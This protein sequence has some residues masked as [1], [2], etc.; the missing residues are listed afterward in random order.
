MAMGSAMLPETDPEFFHSLGQAG[1][2]N[3]IE[4]PGKDKLHEPVIDGTKHSSEFKEPLGPVVYLENQGKK[5]VR[6][7]QDRSLATYYLTRFILT[8]LV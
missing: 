4:I 8:R 6:E 1:I 7:W 5:V 3:H 2:L